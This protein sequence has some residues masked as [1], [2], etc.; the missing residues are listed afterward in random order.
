MRSLLVLI[1][2]MKKRF[3]EVSRGK[4]WIKGKNRYFDKY[5]DGK[6]YDK[7]CEGHW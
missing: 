7:I 5:K 2:I 6:F 4:R 1:G 3:D